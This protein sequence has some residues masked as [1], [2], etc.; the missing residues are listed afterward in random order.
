MIELIKMSRLQFNKQNVDKLF[1]TDIIVTV[2]SFAS[3]EDEREKI[4]K[5]NGVRTNDGDTVNACL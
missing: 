5:L 4:N 1:T 3:R 2:D